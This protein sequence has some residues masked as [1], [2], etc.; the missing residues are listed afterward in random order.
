MKLVIVVESENIGIFD[1]FYTMTIPENAAPATFYERWSSIANASPIQPLVITGKENVF[2]GS[3]WDPATEL[4]SLAENMPTDVAKPVNSKNAV[5][6]IDN[7]IVGT[8]G[9]GDNTSQTQ[10]LEA[11]FSSPVTVF[12]LEDTVDVEV[13]YTWNGNQFIPP[14]I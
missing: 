8:I 10:L 4:F 6:L 13:G 7:V 12:I 11:A 3:K 14:I 1:V 2:I 9:I 5:F